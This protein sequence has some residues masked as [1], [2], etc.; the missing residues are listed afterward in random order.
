MM[1]QGKTYLLT[2]G[3]GSIAGS[4]AQ[5]FGAAGAR[6]AL[7]DSSAEQVN[8]R[9]AQL[10]ARAYGANLNDYEATLTLVN[11]VM[12]DL[13]PID[14]LIHTVGGFTMGPLAETEPKAFDRMFDLNVRTLYHAVRA[15]LPHLIQRQQ[16]F[17]AGISAAPAWRGS[18][19]GMALYGASKEAMASLLRSL[20]GELKGTQIQVAILYPMGTVDT[21]ANRAQMPAAN[22]ETWID[23]DEIAQTLLFAASR[24][25]RG[26]LLEIPL[27]PPR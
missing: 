4:I 12:A 13:G 21:P 10:G 15:V 24:S 14:G 11:H 27:F 9:A 17:I 5:A 23:P 20:D 19:P 3:G 22:P 7:V 18:G 16:G 2:G 26:R 6:L 8:T 25:N 1:L